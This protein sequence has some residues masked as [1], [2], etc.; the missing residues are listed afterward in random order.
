MNRYRSVRAFFA[1]L[2]LTLTAVLL[3]GGILMADMNTR[4]ITFGDTVPPYTAAGAAVSD[5]LD[6]CDTGRLPPVPAA[7]PVHIFLA[8]R[9]LLT[10][11]IPG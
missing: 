7:V 6:S 2:L 8:E 9:L 1:A 3:L 4:R 5:L 11:L 10:W